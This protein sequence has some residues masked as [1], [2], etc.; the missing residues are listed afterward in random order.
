MPT[1]MPMSI[2]ELET[3]VRALCDASRLSSRDLANA[4]ACVAYEYEQTA[5]Q[6]A[7]D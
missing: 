3:V 5:K 2:D 1:L 6:T 7:A 4:L